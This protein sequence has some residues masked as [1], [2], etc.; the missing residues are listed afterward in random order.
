ML[1]WNVRF[2]S[3][4]PALVP[5]VWK[6]NVCVQMC[7]PAQLRQQSAEL[8]ATIDEVLEDTIQKVSCYHNTLWSKQT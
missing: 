6:D 1:D 5:D 2:L 3:W 8:Y 7:S 4:H